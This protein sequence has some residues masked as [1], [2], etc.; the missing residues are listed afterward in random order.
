MA[1]LPHTDRNN[2]LSRMWRVLALALGLIAMTPAIASAQSPAEQSYSRGGPVVSGFLDV[3]SNTPVAVKLNCHGSVVEGLGTVG[4]AW[5]SETDRPVSSWQLWNLQIRPES[6]SRNLVAELGA[7][8]RSYRDTNVAVPAVYAYAVLGLDA[9]GN[10]VARS[11]ID[12]AV[13][14]ERDQDLDLMRLNCRAHRAEIDV[15]ADPA[16][17]VDAAVSVGCDWTAARSE[18]AAGYELWRGVDGGERLLIARMGLDQASVRDDDVSMGHRYR[19][20]VVAVDAD[21]RIVG[22]S[23]AEHVALAAHD[24]AEDR[25]RD[26]EHDKASDQA[27]DVVRDQ[28]VDQVRDQASD[29]VRDHSTDRIRGGV[30]D[31][32]VDHTVDG[33]AQHDQDH[34]EHDQP[35]DH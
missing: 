32:A 9:D 29:V 11:R 35:S 10:I 18:S 24:R 26:S 12:G 16:A 8:V 1:R 30:R 13:L 25:E 5:R 7:D 33:P 4:C 21:G 31:R 19:Y 28:A 14:R 27:R 6:G 3:P 2:R 17:E 15:G 34:V 20:V 23:R 22:R